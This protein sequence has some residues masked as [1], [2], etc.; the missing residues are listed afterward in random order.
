MSMDKLRKQD[1]LRATTMFL[2]DDEIE[3]K[4][5]RLIDAELNAYKGSMLGISTKKG[6]EEYI[7]KDINAI[8]RLTTILGISGERFNRVISLLRFQKGHVFTSEWSDAKLRSILIEDRALMD[9]FCDLLLNGRNLPKYQEI[10]PAFLLNHFHI[11]SEVIARICSNDVLGRQIKSAYSTKYNKEITSAYSKRVD[12]KINAIASRYGLHYESMCLPSV[13][14]DNLNVIHDNKTY[15]IV[16][17]QYSVT[18]GKGQSD[19]AIKMA[20]IRRAMRDDENIRMLIL[21]D[22][23][24]WLVRGADWDKVYSCC[25]FFF[26]LKTL[27]SLEQVIKTNYKI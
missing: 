21:L 4:Y 23:A 24:G 6:L 10:I 19:F 25:D 9:E 2:V 14:K 15:I 12:S 5:Q 11:D 13:S 17:Y 27:D 8:E 1:A 16:C 22:G 20:N 18:T 3:R 26:T 7:R